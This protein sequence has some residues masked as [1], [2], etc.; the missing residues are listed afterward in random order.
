MCRKGR[1]ARLAANWALKAELLA[2]VGWHLAGP[3][4]AHELEE[5]ILFVQGGAATGSQP[6]AS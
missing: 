3:E 2:P 6:P 1:K 4:P 5:R